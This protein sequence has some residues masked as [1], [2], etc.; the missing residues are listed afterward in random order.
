MSNHK[1]YSIMGIGLGLAACIT[2][3]VYFPA[4]AAEQTADKII[5]E[6]YGDKP[7]GKEHKEKPG[8]DESSRRLDTEAKANVA[9]EVLDFITPPADAQQP[10]IKISTPGIAKLRGLMK[11][12]HQAL[13]PFYQS[14]AVGMT[15]DGLLAVRDPEAIPLQ[16]RNPVKQWVV[17]ENRDRNALY[18]EIAQANGH[19]EW[20]REIRNIFASRWIA[21]A[22]A[23]WWYQDT[24]GN[25]RQK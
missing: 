15:S 21:N 5:E 1:R 7:G 20:E 16:D 25:W 6:V 23:G 11:Q 4:A 14:G 9:R 24:S 3:N 22:P 13:M 10:D 8:E 19:P 17:D 2:V 18:P 12:R